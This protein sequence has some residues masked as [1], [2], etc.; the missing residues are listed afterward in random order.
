MIGYFRVS[1]NKQGNSG[2]GLDAQKAAVAAHVAANDCDLIAS[3]CEIETGKKHNLDNRPELLKAIAH[4]KRSKCVLVV[5]KL[6]RLLRSTVVCSTLKTSGVLFTAC[7]N[8]HAN[9]F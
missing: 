6:D 8:P 7:D 4:A 5:A 9:E 2:L 3:Y 1:T